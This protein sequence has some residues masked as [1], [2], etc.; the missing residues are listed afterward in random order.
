MAGQNVTGYGVGD[1][2]L[3]IVSP[4]MPWYTKNSKTMTLDISQVYGQVEAMAGDLKSRQADY[5]R[6]LDVALNTLKTAGSTQDKLKKKIDNARTTWLV[7][8]LRED[9]GLKQ[10]ADKCPDDYVV[11]ASDGSNI[12]VDRHH[13]VRLFLL[14]IGLVYL[15]YGSSPDAEFTTLPMLYFG[16]ERLFIRSDGGKQAQIEGPLLGMKRGI[17]ECRCLADRV[18]AMPSGMPVVGLIDG[19]LIMWGLVGQRYEDFVVKHLLEE[20]L[21]KQLDRFYEVSK[22]KKAAVASYISFPRSADVANVLRLQLCPYDPVDCDKYCPGKFEG[23]ECDAVGGLTDRDIFS[24]LLSDGA[25]SAVFDSS[26]SII[27][28]YGSHKVCFFYI[29]IDDEVAR[30]EVPLWVADSSELLGMVHAFVVEQCRKGFG[31]PVA[32]SEAHEQAV[33]TGAD[34]AQFWDV[35]ERVMLEGN[36]GLGSSLKQRSKKIRWI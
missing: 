35:V 12:D 8:G 36:I 16:E 1:Y 23:R 13:S 7:A 25:R 14:N 24:N 28:R 11:V 15:Q 17:E 27:E 20:G 34:R 22:K 26:S 9:I 6:R 29:R 21:L 33:V 30:V 5:V 2:T 10:P 31:Y 19:S 32:L 18:C 3:M 4:G